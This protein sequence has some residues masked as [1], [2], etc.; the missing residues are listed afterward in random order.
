M[1]PSAY[2]LRLFGLV[3]GA[4]LPSGGQS[5]ELTVC[6]GHGSAKMWTDALGPFFLDRFGVTLTPGSLNLRC[7]KAIDWDGPVN[8]PAANMTWDLCPLILEEKAIG[9]A[10]R[11][12]T[13]EPRY[14]EVISP[15]H[16]RDC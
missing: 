4:P 5:L 2:E 12:N 3:P 13:A 16:L 14:L 10:I 7:E 15:S 9:V 6:S 8:T 11:A 1:A